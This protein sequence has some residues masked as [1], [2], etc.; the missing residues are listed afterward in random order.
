VD[1]EDFRPPAH[2]LSEPKVQDRNL[3]LGVEVHQQDDLG[4]LEVSVRDAHRTGGLQLLGDAAV[5][6]PPVIEV[7][8]PEHR[9]GQLR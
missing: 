7:V 4:S 5:E 6:V 9:A 8:R 1:H 3:L 2:G